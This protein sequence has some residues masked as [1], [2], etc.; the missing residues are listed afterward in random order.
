M[1]KRIY[2]IIELPSEDDIPSK[3]YELFMI[4][5]ILLSMIPLMF[6]HQT[7][8]LARL[9]RCTAIIFSADYLLRLITADYKLRKGALSF[10]IYPFTPLALIDLLSIL[11]SF[12]IL[13]SGFRL[14]KLFRLVRSLRALRALKAFRYSSNLSII[15][16]VIRKQKHSLVAV[17][18][19]AF[20]Y[21]FLC[22]L[23]LFNVEPATFRYQFF[24]ALYWA[25]VSL[26]TTG[27]G[28][29]SPVT[30]LGRLFT[31][32]S[33]VVGIAVVALPSGIITAGFMEE[34]AKQE[35]TAKKAEQQRRKEKKLVKKVKRRHSKLQEAGQNVLQLEDSS[36]EGIGS[37]ESDM[38]AETRIEKEE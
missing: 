30:T 32:L 18:Y 16:D 4:I 25:T 31:M 38:S 7:P 29:I 27:Y 8:S 36:D 28:D 9:D 14:L 35:R 13:S 37:S 12:T 22:A 3:I 1:R 5:I 34:L 11:P 10:V 19:M 23:V 24:D 17:C 6:Y 2:E 15:L 21:I 26:T 33:T 20:A